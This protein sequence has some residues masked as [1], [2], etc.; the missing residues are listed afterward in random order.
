MDLSKPDTEIKAEIEALETVLSVLAP[1]DEATRL[2]V[3]GYV[4]LRFGKAARS[5]P[6]PTAPGAAGTARP[7]APAPPEPADDEFTDIRSLK[8]R[9]RPGNAV[10]MAVLVAY[11]LSELAPENERREAIGTDEITRY[12][13]QAGYRAKG[14]PRVILHRTKNAGYMDSA[15]RGQYRL[16][17]VGLNLAKQGLPRPEGATRSTGV[18]KP[19]ARRKSSPIK[20][21]DSA[22]KSRARRK[23]APRSR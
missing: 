14:Q 22:K 17:P 12:F 15:Q 20:K 11:Y 10:E 18:R 5:L 13:Q 7:L 8:E 16:N 9:K 4:E 2:R 23:R 1:L 21:S 6:L 3:L 19:A